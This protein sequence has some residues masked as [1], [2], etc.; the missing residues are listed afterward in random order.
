M[1]HI[2]ILIALVLATLSFADSTPAV[3]PKFEPIKQQSPILP[4]PT[5][6]QIEAIYDRDSKSAAVGASAFWKRFTKG[7]KYVDLQFFA[8]LDKRQIP[9]GALMFKNTWPV[10][11]QFVVS[12]GP[13]VSWKQSK[14]L[15]LTLFVGVSLK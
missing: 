13:A 10:A 15:G 3:I 4:P 14:L 12:Y 9:V 7:A 5:T 2:L 8:G 1:K 11:D 6:F